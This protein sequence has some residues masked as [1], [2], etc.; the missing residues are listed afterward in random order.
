MKKL[1]MVFAMGT[2]LAICMSG[3]ESMKSM[4]PCNWGAK[5][6]SCT[7]CDKGAACTCTKDVKDAAC[8]CC[9]DGAACKAECCKKV[10]PKACYKDVAVPACSKTDAAK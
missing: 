3:C 1:L 6:V 7:C 8:K 10:A 4:C 2:V 5:D 9:K